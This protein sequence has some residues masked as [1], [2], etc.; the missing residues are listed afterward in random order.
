MGSDDITDPIRVVLA[1]GDP[2]ARRTLREAL[3]AG[4]IRVVAEATSGQEA[5]ALTT[6]Y[7]PDAVMI[8]VRVPGGDG[9]A[10]TS[11]IHERSPDTRVIVLAE[12]DDQTLALRAIRAGASGYLSRDVEPEV[13]PRVVRGVME[14]EAGVSRRVAMQL[15]EFYRR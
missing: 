3:K 5:V 11:E 4:G 10:A 6:F 12:S 8:D 9:V 2:L 7:R 15:L 1:D 13:L 14:G